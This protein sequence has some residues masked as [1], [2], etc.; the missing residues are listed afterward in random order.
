MATQHP[1]FTTDK[2]KPLIEM[3]FK[4]IQNRRQS[5]SGAEFIRSLNG[6]Y[7]ERGRLTEKQMTALKSFY[8][9]EVDRG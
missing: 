9:A 3:M 8:E 4:F 6:F 1:K 7:S 2:D 5:P